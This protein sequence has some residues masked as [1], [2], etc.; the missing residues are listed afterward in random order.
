MKNPNFNFKDSLRDWFDIVSY[1]SRHDETEFK[2]IL[3]Q[4]NFILG[5]YLEKEKF[6]D[7]IKNK[8]VQLNIVKNSNYGSYVKHC[9]YFGIDENVMTKDEFNFVKERLEE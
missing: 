7:I 5:E 6:I 4:Y 1:D 3:E 2:K 9:K 8:Y